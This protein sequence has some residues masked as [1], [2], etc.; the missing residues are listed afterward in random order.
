MLKLLSG[1]YP[2]APVGGEPWNGLEALY[3]AAGT[4]AA[5]LRLLLRLALFG[6]VEE[7]VEGTSQL[8]GSP[9]VGEPEP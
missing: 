7:V 1:F 2:L 5:V 3:L 6:C 8:Q 9:A 4:V